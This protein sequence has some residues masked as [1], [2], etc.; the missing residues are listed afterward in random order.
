[1]SDIKIVS[2]SNPSVTLQVASINDHPE[3]GHFRFLLELYYL[4]NSET[5][6]VKNHWKRRKHLKNLDFIMAI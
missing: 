1:M 4:Q 5:K 2:H 3:P 6:N